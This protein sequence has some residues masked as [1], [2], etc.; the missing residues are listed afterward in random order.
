MTVDDIPDGTMG[1]DVGP[2][3]AEIYCEAIKK[4]KTVFW[5]GPLGVFEKPAFAEGT[6][7]VA[8][9]LAVAEC[10]SVVGG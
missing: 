8:K 10:F 4:A 1:L 5:N 9:T 6:L 2:K 3:T 7:A